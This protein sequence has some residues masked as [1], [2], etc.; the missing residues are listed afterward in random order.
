MLRAPQVRFSGKA[1]VEMSR[2][3]TYLAISAF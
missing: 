1:N 3:I 2:E